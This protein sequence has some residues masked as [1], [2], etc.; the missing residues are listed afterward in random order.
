MAEVAEVVGV[1]ME[2]MVYLGVMEGFRAAALA[3][4]VRAPERAMAELGALAEMGLFIYGWCL[5]EYASCTD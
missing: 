3:A 5:D 1:P 2:R 4:A